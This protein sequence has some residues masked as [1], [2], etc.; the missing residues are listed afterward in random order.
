MA[1]TTRYADDQDAGELVTGGA[2]PEAR[3]Q[4]P[5]EL[6]GMAAN[7]G[8]M[9]KGGGVTPVPEVRNH[10]GVR[11]G[12]VMSPMAQ[13]VVQQQREQAQNIQDDRRFLAAQTAPG[14]Q[15][16]TFFPAMA[17][18]GIIQSGQDPNTVHDLRMYQA[19]VR[20]DRQAEI[21]KEAIDK[22]KS[23]DLGNSARLAGGVTEMYG[24][25]PMADAN[26]SKGTLVPHTAKNVTVTADPKGVPYAGAGQFERPGLHGNGSMSTAPGVYNTAGEFESKVI[27]DR[28]MMDPEK[29]KAE[30]DIAAWK[31]EQERQNN[32]PVSLPKSTDEMQY[33][34]SMQERAN[35]DARLNQQTAASTRASDS[36]SET[37]KTLADAQARASDAG[38]K[39][40]EAQAKQ[41]EALTPVQ[42]DALKADAARGNA[43][44]Q[45]M[46][47]LVDRY[48]AE[49]KE[50]PAD[51]KAR[52]GRYKQESKAVGA[53][54]KE[55][56]EQNTTL[57]KQ[58]KDAQDRADRLSSR[59]TQLSRTPKE[60][61]DA[62][63][64]QWAD[65]DSKTAGTAPSK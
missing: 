26:A 62:L 54:T 57:Q 27:T 60:G 9:R 65:E 55:T 17:R 11:M 36:A 51:A 49:T 15:Q 34:Q 21:D 1:R 44:A 6:D 59:L 23:A 50:L 56:A 47:S 12:P 38:N 7:R 40:T 39:L 25:V 10:G 43:D 48:N 31:S 53:R 42:V 28:V 18:A 22:R 29:A 20:A 5:M 33:D 64:K 19:R 16:R 24:L 58:L 52:R 13:R 32:G 3:E 45:R 14:V 46:L 30:K 35:A 41:V 63:I 8:L 4:D 37:N 2:E 61:I